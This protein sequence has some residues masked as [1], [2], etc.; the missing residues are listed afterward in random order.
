MIPLFFVIFSNRLLF[1]FDRLPYDDNTFDLVRAANLALAVPRSR[2]LPLLQE[3]NRVLRIGGHLELVEDEFFFPSIQHAPVLP[4]MQQHPPHTSLTPSESETER[5]SKFREVE[6]TKRITEYIENA[7]GSMLANKYGIWEPHTQHIRDEL[8]QVFGDKHICMYPSQHIALPRRAPECTSRSNEGFKTPRK[9]SLNTSQGPRTQGTPDHGAEPVIPSS[10]APKAV[11]VLSTGRRPGTNDLPTAVS[12][13]AAR[14][15]GHGNNTASSYSRPY[16]PT[17][18]LVLPNKFFE[19]RPDVLEMH[20]CRNMHVVMSCRRALH[21]YLLEHKASLTDLGAELTDEEF[22]RMFEDAMWEYDRHVFFIHFPAS[23][24]ANV[25]CSF[26]R[27]RLN[28][29]E[30]HPGLLMRI[31]DEDSEALTSRN[32]FSLGEGRRR[33]Q[34]TGLCTFVPPLPAEN[35][36][37]ARVI[38]IFG[39]TKATELR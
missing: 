3:V 11:Q 7:F 5:I 21:A 16:Q 37:Q 24:G 39:A 19:C 8:P 18:F 1:S 20:A 6:E 23:A 2:W 29:P 14:I 22:E 35:C 13:K 32:I 33:A 12:P 9:I 15:L 27:R 17:G 10:A 31:D 25:E 4:V 28:W 30:D 26:K 36:T 34:S 38:R